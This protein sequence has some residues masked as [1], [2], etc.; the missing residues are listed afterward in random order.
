MRAVALLLALQGAVDPAA[1]VRAL[2][3]D[4]P[5]VRARAEAGLRRL[6]EEALP[7]LRRAAEDPSPDVSGRA[8]AIAERIRWDQAIDPL[9]PAR[10]AA[11]RAPF[12]QG[13]AAGMLDAVRRQG[14]IDGYYGDLE[15]FGY[16]L[17]QE[18]PPLQMAGI[19]LILHPNRPG[20]VP[21]R[22][23]PRLLQALVAVSSENDASS[24]MHALA[25]LAY[26]RVSPL[27]R[28]LLAGASS[29]DPRVEAILAVLRAKADVP[30]ARERLPS[31]LETAGQP[32]LWLALQAVRDLRRAEARPHVLRLLRSPATFPAAS[33]A[34]V[35]LEDETC[36][37]AYAELWRKTPPESRTHSHLELFVR[38]DAPER[39]AALLQ[40][41]EEGPP[42]L[43]YAAAK[44]AATLRL[45]AA[46]DLLLAPDAP[47]E[48]RSTYLESALLIVGADDVHRLAAR[49]QDPDEATRHAVR[50]ALI[51]VPDP[52]AQRR[53]TDLLVGETRAPLRDR[54]FDV[55]RC[56]PAAEGLDRVPDAT[57]ETLVREG[58]VDAACGAAQALLKRR[59]GSAVALIEDEALRDDARGPHLLSLLSDR[60]SPRGVA[61]ADR[62]M[63]G[64][65]IA[66]CLVPY[67]ER[68]AT[69]EADAALARLAADGEH[70]SRGAAAHALRRRRGEPEPP[71]EWI[72]VHTDAGRRFIEAVAADAPGAR[73]ELR[74]RVREKGP[75]QC[76]D[77][78]RVWAHP[79]MS[80]AL[81]QGLAAYD[82]RLEERLGNEF[83]SSCTWRPDTWSGEACLRA[84]VATGE[85]SLVPL[86]LE[87]LEDADRGVRA[88]AVEAVGRWRVAAAVPTLRRLV[89]AGGPEIRAHAL[90]ALANIG[91]P[92]ARAFLV[93]VLRDN[94]HAAPYALA[95]L[96]ARDA[97][98][99]IGA[100]LHDG[101]ATAAVVGALELL[102]HPDVYAGLDEPL[103]FCPPN[104][105]PALDELLRRRLGRP[106]RRT[107]L[108]PLPS[109]P[110]HD[111]T[112]RGALEQA[113]GVFPRPY[114][115]AEVAH[116]YRDGEIRLCEPD[117]ARAYWMSRLGLR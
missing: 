38:S 7:L 79:E 116:V 16:L 68:A 85:R 95:R 82:R 66:C 37:A 6:G 42:A 15:A 11:L 32:A 72:S 98:E 1:L 97:L 57:L 5:D 22:G 45:R 52:G 13:D 14:L 113:C 100:L 76:L 115:P 35:A 104:A 83:L 93:E 19:L 108:R 12:E 2:R 55:V 117:E 90:L 17:L 20:A 21:R 8:R 46:L 103:P 3:D 54:L 18:A 86:L 92:G 29:A 10:Y 59:G 73:E 28:V 71:E 88:A 112:L 53:L 106:V 33:E 30:G 94:P 111:G 62:W 107:P 74:R 80:P 105:A 114:S 109:V 101:T 91:G 51:R 23:T 89:R 47:P 110:S 4:A 77:A 87:R 99:A 26:E 31:L 43:R 96:G 34:A 64:R 25:G 78:L 58:S 36:R 81:K 56:L 69:A 67:L 102:A 24:R 41:L 70:P 9:L 44:G 48:L 40:I 60:P 61:A 65:R 27:D 39:E 84:L 50:Y 63:R 75:A 49:L